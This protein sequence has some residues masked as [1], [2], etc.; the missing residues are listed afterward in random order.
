MSKVGSTDTNN[1]DNV[2]RAEASFTWRVSGNHAMSLKYVLSRRD[3][4]YFGLGDRSQARGTIG[5]FYTL[6]GQPG[7][8]AVNWR[9]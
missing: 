8:G 4:S 5:L 7:M 1:N 2:A 3:S 9:R 6:L